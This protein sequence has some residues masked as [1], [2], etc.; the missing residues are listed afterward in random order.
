MRGSISKVSSSIYH[1]RHPE[2]DEAEGQI[3]ALGSLLY[4]ARQNER[5][6]E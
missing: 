2:P 3:R 5:K 4:S 6:A 1:Q